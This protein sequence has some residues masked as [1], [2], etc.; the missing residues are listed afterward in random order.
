MKIIVTRAAVVPPPIRE[1]TIYMTPEEFQDLQVVARMPAE[2]L[3]HA[4]QE[5]NRLLGR[6]RTTTDVHGLMRRFLEI[7]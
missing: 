1:V 6:P 2:V 5:S 7:T 3:W 4:L